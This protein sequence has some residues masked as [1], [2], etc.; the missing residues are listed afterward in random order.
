MHIVKIIGEYYA[1]V[2]YEKKMSRKENFK[3][4]KFQEKKIS[5]IH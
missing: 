2:T 4:R 1:K 3:K 5:I